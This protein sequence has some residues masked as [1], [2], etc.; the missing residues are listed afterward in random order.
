MEAKSANH[1][2]HI[3][4]QI[5][6]ASFCVYWYWHPPAPNKAVLILTGVTVVMALL[7]MSK[8][9]KAVYLLLVICLMFIENRAINK[10]RSDAVAAED[11]RRID[12]NKQF[13]NIAN[14]IQAAITESDRH[15][16]VTMGNMEGMIT[17]EDKNLLQTMGGR[18]YPFFLPTF[19]ITASE[20]FPVKVFYW[21]SKNIPLI[22]VNVDI[23]LRPSNG[24]KWEDFIITSPVISEG[25]GAGNIFHPRHYNL[26][27]ILPGFFESPIQL[28]AGKHY[29]LV[30]TTRRDIF[31][32]KINIDHD[33]NE[34]AGWK[35]SEC[36]YRASDNKLLHGKCN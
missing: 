21:N 30:I 26:G 2:F 15:F 29:Y 7:D 31:Y 34:M 6:V 10:D 9:H 1:W 23:M 27:T 3:P 8:G 11:G 32:E 17:E 35:L 24:E 25:S 20:T 28:E 16:A 13:Q 22:D 4:W 18:G 19:P 12:E 33:A 14:G 36:L 5:I